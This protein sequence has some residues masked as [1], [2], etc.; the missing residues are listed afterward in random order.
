MT[1]L[2]RT[3]DVAG[4]TARAPA[5]LDV[6]V[7]GRHL[8]DRASHGYVRLGAAGES[9]V[10]DRVV[11]AYAAVFASPVHVDVPEQLDAAAALERLG[12]GFVDDVAASVER[13]FG[14][15]VVQAD[16]VGGDCSIQVAGRRVILVGTTSNWFFSTW[17]IAHEL[18]HILRGDLTDGPPASPRTVERAANAFAA[19][20][21]MPAR[22]IESV[23]WSAIGESELADL[24][25]RRGVSSTALAQRLRSLKQE[26]GPV[27][28]RLLSGRTAALVR[29]G[30]I[31][32]R[33]P[34]LLVRRV[35]ASSVPRFPEEL[36]EAHRTAVAE[37]GIG[38]DH[39]DWMLARPGTDDVGRH[40]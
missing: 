2:R 29:R 5:A 8:Y 19:E 25:W 18:G 4:V 40:R 20:L 11:D 9:A 21:L 38:Q 31:L 6:L 28:H 16:N 26:V 15:H 27:A 14:I 7:A 22:F 32:R 30:A 24:V 1:V 10:F 23:D 37:G 36:V 17:S 12:T 33:D 39:L 34:G 13:E 3:L 35:A